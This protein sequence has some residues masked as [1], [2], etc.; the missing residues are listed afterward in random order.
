MPLQKRLHNPNSSYFKIPACW[1]WSVLHISR[2]TVS[3][4]NFVSILRN[5]RLIVFT[6]RKIRNLFQIL[7]VYMVYVYIYV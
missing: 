5:Q 1:C 3:S 4:V 7:T 2:H 6:S